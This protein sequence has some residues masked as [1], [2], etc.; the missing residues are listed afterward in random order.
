LLPARR[1]WPG[2]ESVLKENG[3]LF[4][5]HVTKHAGDA[6]D[7]ARAALRA[8]YEIIAVVGGD[9][10]LSEAAAGFFA[11]DE[12]HAIE[13][14]PA[15]INS[16]A[17]LAIL[18]A[19]TG[20]DFA[21]GLRGRRESLE[22]W[23]ARF[24]SYCRRPDESSTRTIDLIRGTASGGTKSFVC[25][26]VVTVGLGAQVAWRVA[27]QGRLVRRLPGEA[28]F[29]AAACGALAAW[30]E[31]LVRVRVD[32]EEAI[33]CQSNLLAVAN[34]V[35]AGGGM[36]FAP[37]A[38]V[39]DGQMDVLV[40]CNI[41]RATIL[42]ELP[43]IRR[44]GHLANPNVRAMQAKS[45]SIETFSASGALAVEA[46]GNVRGVTPAKFRIMPRALRIIS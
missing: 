10:T 13:D 2:I 26:N 35:Y 18:P 30:R 6:T 14:V 22:E 8:G 44:G 32:E 1:A 20:D 43:R 41:T 16:K 42:R 36:M 9:G 46:D 15:A 25:I 11:L 31:R 39:D 45:V 38:R 12:S 33:E 27:A 19:G 3:I 24:V 4:D 37:M 29:M 17:V 23:L 28:R 40:S 21:R 7:A 5:S 34:G